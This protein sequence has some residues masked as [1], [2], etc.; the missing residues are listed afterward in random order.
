MDNLRPHPELYN[1]P[2]ITDNFNGMPYHSLGTSGLRASNSGLG[3]WKIGHP[4]TGDGSRVNEKTALKIFDR[5]VELGVTFWDTAN[6]YNNASGNS[7]RIIG[8]WMSKNL[9]QRRNIVLATKLFGGMDGCTPNHCR[10]SRGNILESVYASLER[11][12]IDYIDLLFFHAFDTDTNVEESLEAIED[13]VKIDLIRYF[14]VSNFTVDNL[15]VYQNTLHK[16]SNRCKIVAVQNQFDII[17]RES[18][19]YPDVLKYASK[20]NMSFIAWGPLARGLLTERYLDISKV[21]KGDRLY[22]EA[23]LEKDTNESVMKKIKQLV[24]LAH[25]WEMKL[26]ELTIAYMLTIPGMGPVIPS[27]STIQHVESIAKGGKITLT[28]EQKQQIKKVID[29]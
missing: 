22:D 23:T 17:Y 7:E 11:L 10:L 15:E 24:E 25:S 29:S 4:E 18:T 19:S 8:T 1:I 5:A 20:N 26:S 28:D 27:A 16:F 14:G 12:Q 13:L 21:G 3:T 9:D 6:R 2:W